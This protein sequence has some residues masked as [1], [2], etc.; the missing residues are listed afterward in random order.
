[1]YSGSCYTFFVDFCFAIIPRECNSVHLESIV[2]VG[3]ILHETKWLDSLQCMGMIIETMCMAHFDWMWLLLYC[4]GSSE[5]WAAKAAM[6][7]QQRRVQ[8]QTEQYYSQAAMVQG[9]HGDP[10]QY[11]TQSYV[12]QHGY[13]AQHTSHQSAQKY[14]KDKQQATDAP[15]LPPEPEEEPT[16][17]GLMPE[18]KIPDAADNMEMVAIE[19]EAQEAAAPTP[20]VED[21]P[22]QGMAPT[23]DVPLN[24]FDLHHALPPQPEYAPSPPSV[25]HRE[26][27]DHHHGLNALPP[28]QPYSL[29][30]QIDY[31]HQTA[32]AIDYNHQRQGPVVF[33]YSRQYDAGYQQQLPSERYFPPVAPPAEQMPHADMP[34][35][36]SSIDYSGLS[37]MYHLQRYIPHKVLRTFHIKL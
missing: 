5:D 33:D 37:G 25:V 29:P 27:F 28:T 35:A 36:P 32:S 1:M 18:E 2:C 3:F 9:Y 24:S 17:P 7:A 11:Q 8:E 10:A 31:G 16:P 12:E 21:M 4:A 15:P 13:D 26:T 23:P 30:Q 34:A 6:W 22:G 19:A 14:P 20:P